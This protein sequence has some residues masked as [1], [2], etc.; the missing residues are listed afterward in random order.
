MANLY[1]IHIG[2][3]YCPNPDPLEAPIHIFALGVLPYFNKA[4]DEH[5]FKE[6]FTWKKAWSMCLILLDVHVHN[7]IF[8]VPSFAGDWRDHITIDSDRAHH[9]CEWKEL[10]NGAAP[11]MHQYIIAFAD[12]ESTGE[13]LSKAYA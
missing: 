7:G 2:T 13:D 4:F 10:S 3:I 5:K 11:I 9:R 8:S 1:D 6:F 12:V